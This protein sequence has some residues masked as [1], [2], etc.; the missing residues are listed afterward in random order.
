MELSVAEGIW[1]RNGWID[2]P[3]SFHRTPPT[4]T[5]VRSRSVRTNTYR[6]DRVTWADDY[7]PHDNTPGRARWLSY[8]A[9]RIARAA[10][11]RHR[12][13]DR[14]WLIGIH[15]W[16][17][18]RPLMD[19]RALRAAHLHRDLGCNVALITLPLHGARKPPGSG[20]MAGFP[21]PDMIDSFH[22]F[23]QAVW[24]VRQ[25]ISWIRQY[26]DQPVGV[27]GQS[28]GGYTAALVA[29]V[30][31]RIHAALPL[32]PAVDLVE[33]MSEHAGDAELDVMGPIAESARRVFA[34]VAPL[35]LE[36][37]V[38]LDRRFIVAGTLDQFVRPSTQAGALWDHWDRC[39]LEWF[40]GTHVGL[41]WARGVQDAIDDRLRRFGLA[42]PRR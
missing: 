10:V 7:A 5:G 20:P 16:G 4:P 18:G 28:L 29:S 41:F 35:R 37:K 8:D 36:P 31:D 19:L 13:K 9:N 2:D 27:F 42:K 6:Y 17:L 32:I 39:D 11:L 40:H 1:E 25:L 22:G 14:P 34:P 3:A 15:G 33:L 12:G 24:D 30:D 26:T 21:S 23:E 38:P